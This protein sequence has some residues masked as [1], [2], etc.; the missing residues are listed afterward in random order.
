MRTVKYSTVERYTVSYLNEVAVSAPVSLIF[1]SIMEISELLEREP[2]AAAAEAATEDDE[3][4]FSQYYGMLLH[5]QNMLQDRVRTSTYERAVLENAAGDFRDKVVLD[6]GTG[7]G[8]LAYFALR[9][10]ARR[11]YAVELSAM[12]D[13]A[14]ALLA[15][16]GFTDRV[17]VI[18]G[19]M[20]DV[21]LPE[22]VDVVL[23]EPMGFF[24]VHERML[25]TFVAAG[26]KWRRDPEA[27]KMYPSRGTMFAAP[28][29]D[30]T[31]FREQATKA[32]FWDQ[33]DFYG[34]DLSV[35]R[36]RAVENHFSQPVVGYFPPELLIAT[37]P[38]T[39]VLDFQDVTMEELHTFD[40]PF[41]FEIA[42]TG[43]EMWGAYLMGWVRT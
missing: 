20:E 12:A 43:A 1:V 26:K 36:T 29:S 16:N 27:V 7:S 42:K 14:R 32:A 30:D 4:P 13:C 38:A 2:A 6:V 15:H 31:L 37:E 9:A 23:S 19:K 22:R 40:M 8:I 34:L 28:F 17:K 11:V 24:L 35:L 3:N 41:R 39:H 21:E 18:R 33:R 25:E 10:G 5:Q